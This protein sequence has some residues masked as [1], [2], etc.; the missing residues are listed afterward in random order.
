[1]F[2]SAHEALLVV[3]AIDTRETY[4]FLNSAIDSSV[5][6]GAFEARLAVSHSNS[7]N[8]RTDLVLHS[9]FRAVS[10]MVLVPSFARAR[11]SC[12]KRW[13]PSFDTTSPATVPSTL[14]RW[15]TLPTTRLAR[16]LPW[17]RRDHTIR[18]QR[19]RNGRTWATTDRRGSSEVRASSVSERRLQC[20]THETPVSF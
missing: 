16:C 17:P 12:A 3:L 6:R 9:S 8:R 11:S 1:M 7:T 20:P 5:T 18:A 10:A 19:L 14:Q 4:R 15:A 13:N 2:W